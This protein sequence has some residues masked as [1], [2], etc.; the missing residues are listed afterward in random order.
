ML[1]TNPAIRVLL[2]GGGPQDAAL[3]AQ[4]AQLGVTDKVIFTGRVPHHDVQRYYNLVDVLVYPRLKMRLTDLVTPLKP[5]EAMA[6]GRLLVASDV[7]GHRE[8]IE[9]GKTGVLFRAGDPLALAQKTL[10]LLD[11]PERWAALREQGRRFVENERSWKASVAR[12]K[13]VYRGVTGKATP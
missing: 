13:D 4:A 2:V 1:E 9:D 5:L 8:L 10:A 12:Y 11:A 6:Q 7:G 3:K